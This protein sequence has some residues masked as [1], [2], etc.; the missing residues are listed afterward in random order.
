[1]Y[2][3]DVLYIYELYTQCTDSE[4]GESQ[5]RGRKKVRGQPRGLLFFFTLARL[6][7]F[8]TYSTS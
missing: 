8:F 6:I 7:L 4:G 5:L 1:M 3:R 2:Y